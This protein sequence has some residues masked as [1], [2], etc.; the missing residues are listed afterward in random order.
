[1]VEDGEGLHEVGADQGQRGGV[2]PPPLMV[3]RK[4]Y[5]DRPDAAPGAF[6]RGVDLDG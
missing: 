1:M 4:R 5:M 3:P 2:L 6:A